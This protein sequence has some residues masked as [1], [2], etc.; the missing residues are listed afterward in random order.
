MAARRPA[1]WVAAS[2]HTLGVCIDLHAQAQHR[3]KIEHCSAAD[4]HA[5][6]QRRIKIEH[7]CS[8]A[9]AGT[10]HICNAAGASTFACMH[11]HM[12]KYVPHV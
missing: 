2:T 9:S 8:A 6:A 10:N 12:L 4:L 7:Y 1:L 5:Q 11:A 3:I